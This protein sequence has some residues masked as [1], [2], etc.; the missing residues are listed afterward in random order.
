MVRTCNDCDSTAGTNRTLPASTAAAIPTTA[1]ET[2]M[3]RTMDVV[4]V[5]SLGED[6]E[7]GEQNE[8]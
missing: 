1:H 2:V 5:Q 6:G 4:V 7:S 3:G 8:S